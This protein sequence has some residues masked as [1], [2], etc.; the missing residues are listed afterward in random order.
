LAASKRP[1]PEI[2]VAAASAAA[3]RDP[4]RLPALIDILLPLDLSEE[5][6]GRVVTATT[7]DRLRLATALDGQGRRSEAERLY[8][9]ASGQ[10][11]PDD[12]VIARWLLAE[13]LLR[14]G[15]SQQAIAELDAAL[16]REPANPE[17]RLLRGRARAALED[18]AALEDYRDA[19][20]S[21]AERGGTGG[22]VTVFTATE[23]RARA[24][25]VARLARDLRHQ[26]P[27]GDVQRASDD[28][29]PVL[30]YQRALAQY[31]LHRKLWSQ[32]LE[33][34]N[35]VAAQEPTDAAAQFA[36]AQA[37]E[38]LG[39]RDR[40][41]EAYRKAVALDGDA[42][43]RFRLAQVFWAGDQYVQAI[44]QWRAIA[45]ADPKNV[46]AHMALGAAYVKIGEPVD[47]FREY[48]RVLALVPGHAGA[49]QALARMGTR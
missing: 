2:A 42:R 45:E 40:A 15:E 48:Q 14:K 26:D 4:G 7:L 21:A 18:P 25:I 1:R 3:A 10:A 20:I 16:Q 28:T 38:A 27:V 11:S 39:Q 43:Y 9:Q 23:P 30:R 13:F 29:V 37:L 22:R 8:R 6:W 32:A 44:E 34:W 19:V 24:L 31:L 41:I 17:L 49:L 47:G 12:S 33:A 46:D 36:R 5:Q 35:V